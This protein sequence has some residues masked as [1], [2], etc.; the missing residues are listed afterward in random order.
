MLLLSSLLYLSTAALT[1]A[2][3]PFPLE[4][5]SIGQSCTT[6]VR[7]CLINLVSSTVSLIEFQEGAGTCQN[8]AD[9]TTQGF[10][11][12]GHCPGPTNIQ[13][14]VKKTCNTGS[15]TGICLNT[16]DK[17]GGS[18]V[19][20]HCPGDSTIQVCT[21]PFEENIEACFRS[22]QHSAARPAPPP[23]YHQ[24]AAP[25]NLSSTP[26]S[27][28]KASPTSGAVAAAPAP[29][30]AVSTALASPNTP[31]AN[32]ATAPS[33]APPRPNTT[34]PWANTYPAPMPNRAI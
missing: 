24:V 34:P 29:P 25:A 27:K 1:P 4:E 32:P 12:A 14:C 6:P 18:F 11:I 31:P 5:R 13:C 15:A 8:T 30:P 7:L 2:S 28:K 33:P 26:R 19:A 3:V 16:S 23:H 20:G 21:C 17:C 22:R 9:C 10:N